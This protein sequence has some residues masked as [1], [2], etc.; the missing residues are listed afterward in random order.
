MRKTYDKVTNINDMFD[1]LEERIKRSGTRNIEDD[2]FYM[3][4]EHKEMYL[5]IKGYFNESG[6]NAEID[7]ACY[8]IALPEIFKHID[9]FECAHP[10]DWV[11]TDGRLSEE[12]K[13]L[14]PHFQY[15]ALAA[16]EVSNIK[17]NTKPALSLG[18]NYWNLEQLKVFWQ[19]TAIRR[20]NAM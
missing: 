8:I 6:T 3:N 9:I 12:F 2:Y 1:Y 18:L 20:K 7:A 11:K 16:A 4:H 14:K 10:L 13:A 5:S 17:F 19:F 15:F